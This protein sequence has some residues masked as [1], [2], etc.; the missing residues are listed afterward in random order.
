MIFQIELFSQCGTQTHNRIVH[1]RTV[2]H[3]AKLA[4]KYLPL[5]IH[6]K[7]ARIDEAK[8]FKKFRSSRP[9]MFCKKGVLRNFAKFTGRHLCQSLF[10]NKVAGLK[11]ATLLKKRFWH[12][13][14]PVNFAKFLRIPFSCRTPP[15]AASDNLVASRDYTS[16]RKENDFLRNYNS[17]N[18]GT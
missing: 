7:L 2:N 1:K 9:E 16:K 15:V 18:I 17:K 8:H 14:F 5:R 12:R 10:F 11:P 3:L 4:L 13:C 6:R